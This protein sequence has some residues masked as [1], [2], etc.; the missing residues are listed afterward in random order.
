MLDREAH[1]AVH[2]ADPRRVKRYAESRRPVWRCPLWCLLLVG[3]TETWATPPVRGSWAGVGDAPIVG[4]SARG[5]KI[6]RLREVAVSPLYSIRES[7][8]APRPRQAGRGY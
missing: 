4:T 8:E 5:C 1:A 6:R 2:L 3:H 7:E